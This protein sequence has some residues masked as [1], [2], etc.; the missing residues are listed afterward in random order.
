MKLRRKEMD[1]INR[2]I[3]GLVFLA[4]LLANLVPAARAQTASKFVSARGRQFVLPNGRPI[5]LKGIN[6]GNWLLPEGYMFEFKKANSAQK[7]YEVFNQL[8][9]E[10]E[11]RKFWRR[12]APTNQR[13]PCCPPS[14]ILAVMPRPSGLRKC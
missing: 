2:K 4:A 14:P 7:I 13:K 6:L 8:I 9:G 3:I 5:F 11:A 10:A 12:P 1:S